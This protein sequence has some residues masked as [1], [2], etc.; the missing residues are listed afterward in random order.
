MIE[1]IGTVLA[2]LGGG[3]VMFFVLRN[4]PRFLGLDNILKGLGKKYADLGYGM[5]EEWKSKVTEWAGKL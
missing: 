4:N 5:K 2:F 3:V 1:L